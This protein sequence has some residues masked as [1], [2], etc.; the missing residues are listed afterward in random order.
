[1]IHPKP[2]VL[3]P[4]P[5]VIEVKRP[6]LHVDLQSHLYKSSE[7]IIDI[8]E[9][10]KLVEKEVMTEAPAATEELLIRMKFEYDNLLEQTR[11]KDLLLNEKKDFCSRC[12]K[13]EEKFRELENNVR[14]LEDALKN[15]ERESRGFQLMERQTL[16]E[17]CD[18]LEG[19]ASNADNRKSV[20]LLDQER[21]RRRIDSLIR[22]TKSEDLK[23]EDAYLES[24]LSSRKPKSEGDIRVPPPV[25]PKIVF[26]EQHIGDTLD[27][28]ESGRRKSLKT[29]RERARSIFV[30][31]LTEGKLLNTPTY[32]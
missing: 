5:T 28:L 11:K 1:M 10:K 9:E 6:S 16:D 24:A 30:K 32:S 3:H 19:V 18:I 27:L 14:G 12:E 2:P 20:E 26:P 31:L 23:R 29:P 7:N 13:V 8:P 25:P 17:I 15:K 21:I 22:K 4:K